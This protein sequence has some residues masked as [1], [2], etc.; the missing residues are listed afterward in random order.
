MKLWLYWEGEWAPFLDLCLE[1]IE[2]H[3][4]KLE[5][6]LLDPSTARKWVPL[7]PKWDY[8]P[9]PA[10]RADYLRARLLYHHGG[11]WLDIDTIVLEEIE[12]L[13]WPL[14]EDVDFVASGIAYGKPSIG[15][16]AAKPGCDLLAQWVWQ[17]NSMLGGNIKKWSE[18]GADVLWPLAEGYEYYHFPK[19]VTAPIAWCEAERFLEPEPLEWSYRDGV[20]MYALYNQRI[21]SQLRALPKEQLVKSDLLI[22]RLF[23]R[24]LGQ[25]G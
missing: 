13:L 2:K 11:V 6:V 8:L 24:A 25:G 16:L 17:M 22:A 23:R 9:H 15:F 4:G 21:G 19:W 3:R 5:I 12:S 18:L 7:H 20:A 14:E 1:T 10:H